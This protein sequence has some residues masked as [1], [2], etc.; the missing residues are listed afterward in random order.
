MLAFIA[1]SLRILAKFPDPYATKETPFNFD[2]ACLEAFKKLRSL[3]SSAMK[4]PNWSF[5]FEIMCDASDYAVG[6]IL[7]QRES[8]L[9]H[10][11]YYAS[12]TLLEAQ[13]NYTQQRMSY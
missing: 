6:A 7:G 1:A 12:K 13:V 3:L 11:I 5:P 10:M 4:T 8:K 9:P 2:E